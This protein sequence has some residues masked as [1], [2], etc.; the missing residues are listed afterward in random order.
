MKTIQGEP[1][2]FCEKDKAE[3]EYTPAEKA[4]A[5]ARQTLFGNWKEKLPN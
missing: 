5:Q 1:C 2:F 3:L 4:L